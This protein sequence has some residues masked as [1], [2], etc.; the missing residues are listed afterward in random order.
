MKIVALADPHGPDYMN[1]HRLPEGDVLIVCGD[2]TYTGDLNELRATAAAL[3]RQPHAHKIVI[4]GNHDFCLEGRK[5]R[6]PHINDRIRTE[7]ESILSNAG[8][9]YLN[10]TSHH[11]NGV[12]FYGTPWTPE[13]HAWAFNADRNWEGSGRKWD[14]L[15]NDVDVLLAHGPPFGYGDL[16]ANNERVGCTYMANAIKTKCPRFVCY[17]HIHEDVGTRRLGQSTL[18]NCSIGY[19]VHYGMRQEHPVVFE[20][21]ARSPKT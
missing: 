10:Q 11:I 4:A 15:P 6:L 16:T 13:Y 2:L 14:A 3:E 17:G 19:P 9:V 1:R 18:I 5:F 21:D 7:A 20:L 8:L 12:H